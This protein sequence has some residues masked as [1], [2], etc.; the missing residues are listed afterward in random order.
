MAKTYNRYTN[1]RYV[2]DAPLVALA[3]LLALVSFNKIPDANDLLFSIIAIILWY[4]AGS[5]SKLHKDRRSDKFSEEIVFILY[6][7]LLYG[8][9]ISSAA[10]FFR[11]VFAFTSRLLLTFISILLGLVTIVKYGL[12]KYLH[13]DIYK[14]NLFDRIVLIGATPGALDFYETINKYYYYGYKCLGFLDNDNTQL[15]GCHYLG[16]VESLPKILSQQ[17][18]DEVIIAL[19]HTS[20][21][22]IHQCI[23]T[24]EY[25]RVKTRIIADF[26][27]YSTAA[28]QVNNIGLLPV[29]NVRPLPL[30]KK[31]N[32]ILKRVFDIFF[33]V[34]F[35]LFLGWWVLPLIAAVIKI[36]S[37]GPVFFKQ[38]RWGLNNEKISCYKFRSM[39]AE[40][41][42]TDEEGT[43]LQTRKRDPRVTRLGYFLRKTNIDELPQFWN[44]LIGNMSVVGPRPHPTP[45]NLESM[46]TVENY[47]LRHVVKP[48]ITGWAQVNGCRGETK[49]SGTM[50]KRVNFDLYY[51][52]KWTFWLD[53]QIILQTIIN[54][55]RGD[56]D[57]Y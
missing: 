32:K 43:Y 5:F 7:L 37:K 20:I 30:D 51:I 21:N 56:Q 8:I 35:F 29:M 39:V 18:V 40:A 49:V 12:R 13:S 10:F 2:I 28:I 57:A 48:G 3:Y 52:H 9:L 25:Y 47:M 46:H 38:E 42:E 50:Q 45:L 23:E 24:C 27:Q 26:Y 17:E 14:G 44:V 36:T 22:Q 31:E 54:F 11:N 19:P 15:N 1:I 33:T 4:V 34:C 41:K 55:F 53:I 6:T 16:Q